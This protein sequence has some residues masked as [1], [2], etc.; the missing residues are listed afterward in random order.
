VLK[1]S[2]TH[3]VIF[4]SID[5]WFFLKDGLIPRCGLENLFSIDTFFW[6]LCPIDGHRFIKTPILAKV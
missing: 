4:L 6:P 5:E 1:L 2:L 3:E